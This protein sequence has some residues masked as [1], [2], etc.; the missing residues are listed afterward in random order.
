MTPQT[1]HLLAQV[2]RH[3]RALATSVET[4]VKS[5]AFSR[6]EALTLI[7]VFRGVLESVRSAAECARH[8]VTGE[9]AMAALPGAGASFKLGDAANVLTEI[10][11]YLNEIA[12]DAATDEL[13]GTT[14]TPGATAPVKFIVF[15]ATERSYALS[16]RWLPITETFFAAID[17]LQ[18][19]SYEYGPEGTATGKTKI[20]G[21]VNVG[22]W[23]GPQQ[24]VDGVIGFTISLKVNTIIRTTF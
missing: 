21:T 8:T 16:G 13:D 14:F 4:R 18:N 22:A 11:I 24:A 2:I 9:Q 15:G 1:V 5:E 10:A 12:S 3:Q 19:R 17:G 7:G 20:S 6:E 23:S